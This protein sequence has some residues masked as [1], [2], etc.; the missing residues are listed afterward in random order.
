M[1][2]GHVFRYGYRVLISLSSLP[3]TILVRG[4]GAKGVKQVQVSKNSE[5]EVP[6]E[7]GGSNPA[8]RPSFQ[9]R[10]CL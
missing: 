10:S 7:R 6:L 2:G 4:F 9:L 1:N 5:K 3:T 8:A